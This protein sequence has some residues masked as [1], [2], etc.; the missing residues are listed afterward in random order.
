MHTRYQIST[1]LLITLVL[2]GFTPQV[3]AQG[4]RL[5][6]GAPGSK[7]MEVPEPENPAVQAVLE[8]KPGTPAE[9][10]RAAGQLAAFKRPDLAKRFLKIVL[11]AKLDQQQLTALH[12]R[13]G[14]GLFLEMATRKELAPEAGQLKEAVLSAVDRDLRDPQR[15]AGLIDQL[16]DPSANKRYQ[17]MDGLRRARSASV[18]PMLKVL[19][20]PAQA[21]KH[22]N[23]RAAMVRIGADAVAPLEAVLESPDAR[24]QIEAI[25]LL[26]DLNARDTRPLLLATLASGERSPEVR[27]AAQQAYGRLIGHPPEGREAARMLQQEAERYA[28]GSQPLKPDDEGRVEL[29]RWDEAKKEPVSNRYPVDDARRFLAS[30]LARAA[31]SVDPEDREIL[32]LHLATLLEWARY[33]NGLDKPLP[34]GPGT[35][36]EYAARARF[37]P[38]VIEEVLRYA[39]DRGHAGAATAAARILGRI[40]T[41]GQLLEQGAEPAPLVR[42][43]RHADRRLRFAAVEAILNLEPMSPFPGSSYVSDA[44]AFFAASRGTRRALV[45]GPVTAETRRVAGYLVAMGYEP[46]TA[47]TGREMLDKALS[48]PDYELALVDAAL[49]YPTPDLLI[50]QLHHDCHT[51]LLPVGIVARSGQLERAEHMARRDRL[52]AAF[53]RPHTADAVQWQ[54]EQLAALVG[55]EAV[56][57]AERLAQ[58]AQAL[59]WLDEL[60]RENPKVFF[61]LRRAEGAAIGALYVPELGEKASI[62]VAGMGTAESQTA[63]VDLASRWTQ[64][65]EL[66][67]AA[68]KAFRQSI[69]EHGILLTSRQLLAQ[70]DRYNESETLDVPS[71][72]ILGFLLDCIETP[73]RLVKQQDAARAVAEEKVDDGNAK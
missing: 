62:V 15:L 72:R 10:V 61:N 16:V 57:Q 5:A 31:Y 39:M 17:A 23:V 38:G 45:A 36:A 55:P 25:R 47:V 66:R 54:V 14:S 1:G 32:L 18:G 26:A 43:A 65:V 20:D 59:Q 22:A 3:R 70:Y 46:D 19:A 52:A 41:A 68:A 44:L 50:Q 35:A 37:G 9:L 11:E 33:E 60:S 49:G 8:S 12:D 58:A 30:R 48:S 29:W 73:T 51:A 2:A 67:G 7:P 28:T 56:S 71:Q 42:A 64:P 24:L 34:T 6:T 53:V 27:V 21:A 40:G 13:F 4:P 69:Q 63:L